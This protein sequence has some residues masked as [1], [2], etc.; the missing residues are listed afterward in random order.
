MRLSRQAKYGREYGLKKSEAGICQWSGCWKAARLNRSMCF[1]H[2][3]LNREKAAAYYRKK[4]ARGT[5]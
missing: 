3:K 1:K 5:T 4:V 2:E